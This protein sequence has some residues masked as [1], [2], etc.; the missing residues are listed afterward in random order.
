VVGVDVIPGGSL[1][2]LRRRKQDLRTN[3]GSRFHLSP[4]A[5]AA[6]LN[7]RI[8]SKIRRNAG[9]GVRH[10]VRYVSRKSSHLFHLAFFGFWAR[11]FGRLDILRPPV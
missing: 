3:A 4:T 6:K 7:S 1:G 2:P 11:T 5:Q 8:P 10:M 9:S